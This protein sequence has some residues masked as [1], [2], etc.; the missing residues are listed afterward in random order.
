MKS[1]YNMDDTEWNALVQAVAEHLDDNTVKRGHRYYKQGRVHGLKMTS[2]RSLSAVVEGSDHY[3]VRINLDFPT[4]SNCSCP[5]GRICKHI[6]AVLL[7]YADSQNCPVETLVNAKSIVLTKEQ[8]KPSNTAPSF[9]KPKQEGSRSKE[10]QAKIVEQA[11]RIPLMSIA[12]WHG[13][14]ELCTATLTDNTRNVSYIKDA[15]AAIY[16]I[17]PTFSP[18]ME[19]M[20]GLHVYLFILRK[21][22]K[23]SQ[24]WSASN[25][26]V[27]YN[28]QLAAAELLEKIGQCF[29]H[30]LLLAAE[31]EQ[32]NRLL[33]T[34]A[35]LRKAMLTESPTH[36]YFWRPY[37]QF[38]FHWISP[39]ISD[40]MLYSEELQQLKQAKDE[41]GAALFPFPWM[42]AQGWMYFYLSQDQEASELLKA[43][44]RITDI[45]PDDL[46]LFLAHLSET[47]QWPRLAAWLF[48]I[49]P[50][51]ASHRYNYMKDYS[52]YW[53]T[54][55]GQAPESEQRLWDALVRMLPY[56]GSVYETKMIEYAKWREWMDYQLS[57]GREPLEFRVSELQPLEKHAP[58]VLLPFFH[59]AVERYV[60][61]KKRSSYK[62]AVK[63]LK[64]LAKLYKKMKQE[65]RWDLFLGAFANRNSR[66]RALQEELRKGKL[67]P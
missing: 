62:S 31:P 19:Q 66:L 27:G 4:T 33:Q 63:L 48:E 42:M 52:F 9:S 13:L 43:A 34:L 55:L 21:L 1:N 24:Q 61:Q 3:L 7:E 36:A 38:W 11:S 49:G 30:N 65:E 40:S 18:A 47:E 60:A 41:L 39:N 28:T 6:V 58:E 15:A 14:F 46:F 12:E 44:H 8:V 29:E 10:N 2:A 26:F 16:K 56:S 17:K 45:S 64:R 25:S 67:V 54:A 35:Y 59:Q 50:L 57:A 53:E 37:V 23:P 20:F 51:L 22:S 32:W 5:V